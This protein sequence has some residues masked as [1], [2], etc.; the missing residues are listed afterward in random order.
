MVTLSIQFEKFDRFKNFNSNL[1][2]ILNGNFYIE[3]SLGAFTN[4]SI[5][6][7]RTSFNKPKQA[8]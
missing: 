3:I 6:L 4:P 2:Y 7:E 5:Y 1:A 8:K